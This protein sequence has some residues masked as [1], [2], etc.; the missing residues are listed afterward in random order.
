MAQELSLKD[1]ERRAW[2][3]LFDDGLADLGLGGLLLWWGV[4][5]LL[6]QTDLSRLV[7]TTINLSG[8][9]LLVLAFRLAKRY[10]TVPRIGRARFGRRRIIRVAWAGVVAAVLV[11]T[12]FALTVVAIGRQ[13]SLLGEAVSPFVSPV[14]LGVFFLMLFGVPAFILDYRRLYVVALM[15]ALPEVVRTVFREFWG[16]DPGAL[17][18][19]TAAAAIVIGMGATVLLR[20]LRAHPVPQGSEEEMGDGVSG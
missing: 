9:A 10:V 4:I 18:F 6:A 2:L 12:T 19:R 13:Q 17:V 14:L 16:L 3:S 20:F 1:V 5:S 15:F 8:Y 11:N 7:M